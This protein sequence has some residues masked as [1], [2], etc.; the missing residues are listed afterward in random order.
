VADLARFAEIIR[1][2][3]GLLS[4]RELALIAHVL[5]RIDGDDAS[6]LQLGDGRVVVA[7]EAIVP[8]LVESDPFAAGAAAVVTNVS[9]IR[10]MGGRPRALVD[11]LVSP[12]RGH[13]ERV[14][15]GLAW[16]SELLGVEVVGGH[17]TLGGPP[18]LSAF[19]TGVVT[20]PLRASGARP[21]DTL[22]AAF[23][24]EG[25]YDGTAPFFSSLRERSAE[26]LRDDGEALVEAAERSLAHAARDVSMPGVG[27]SL[28]QLLEL[29]GCGATLEVE[30]LPRP[31]G[32]PLERW[33]VTFPSFGFVL[34]TSPQHADA[35]CQLFRTRGLA[36][37]TVGQVDDTRVLRITAGRE[38]ATVWDLA[39]EPLTGLGG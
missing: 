32:V 21:G 9:D 12:D 13:A 27:G 29:A 15:E 39:R 1:T 5:P 30:R 20:T 31:Q 18:A 8:W 3:P 28:L 4:K 38:A 24:L 7:G 25:R 2:A 33:L 10:A 26:Q 37:D 16:A 6:V 35:T 19:C 11:T 34:A 14:L 36:A 23:C 17:L 22:V